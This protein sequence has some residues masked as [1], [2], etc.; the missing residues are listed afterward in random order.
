MTSTV[1]GFKVVQLFKDKTLGIGSF[2]KVCKA[3]CDDLLCAAKILHPTLF[4]PT[5]MHHIA[6]HQEHRLPIERFKQECEFLSALRHPNIVQYLGIHQD[7]DM[8]LA[9]LLNGASRW[10]LNKPLG[11][12]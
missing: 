1:L 6:R 3:K 2:G 8:H 7:P 12:F 11:R 10:Q 4:D 9:T 5:V